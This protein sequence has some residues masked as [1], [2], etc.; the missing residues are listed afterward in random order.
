MLRPR[1]RPGVTFSELLFNDVLPFGPEPMYLIRETFLLFTLNLLDAFLTLLWVR[2][3]VAPEGN[4]IM[5]EL[6]DVGDHAFIGAKVAMGM[7]TCTVLLL[8]GDRRLAKL[9]VSFAL[10]VYC[11][12]MAV[13]FLTGLTAAGIYI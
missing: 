7:L 5:A 11:G 8:W 9:G 4:H 3:G 10:V 12:V 2:N 1:L 13:H 6:L